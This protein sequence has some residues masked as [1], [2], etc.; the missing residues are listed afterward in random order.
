L[1]AIIG[2]AVSELKKGDFAKMRKTIKI[3]ELKKGMYIILPSSWFKHPFLK[4]QFLVQTDKQIKTLVE[5]DFQE[6]T[7]D[8]DQGF[9]VVADLESTGHGD[10][11]L[12]PPK[13]WNSEKLAPREFKEMIQSATLEPKKKA[14]VVYDHS[15]HLM[16]E[17]FESPKAENIQEV[18]EAVYDIVDLILSEEDTPRCLLELTNHDF[19][20]YTHSV[21][22]GVLC[23][24][25]AK[26][27]F[28]SQGEHNMREL[29]A[30]FF[31]HDLG[32]VMIRTEVLN[33]P[34]RLTEEEM[35]HIRTHPYQG[36]KIMSKTGQLSKE[37]KAIVMQH[38]EREDGTG[39]PLGLKGNEI[40]VYG[41]ICCIADIFDALTA[42]RSYKPSLSPFEALKIMKEQMVNHFHPEVFQSFVLLFK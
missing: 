23:I 14:R 32:K 39:Y 24:S 30:G 7:I 19:Y 41:R 12:P 2:A 1:D 40:H 42:E 35:R 34:G 3:G 13:E 38:H 17:L 15:L 28:K 9:D 4:N 5:S 8:T 16:Q 18:K 26:A 6:V 25:L 33:K 31:L 37:C 21:N 10:K 22:V 36:H 27:L 20:T 29:G 11:D